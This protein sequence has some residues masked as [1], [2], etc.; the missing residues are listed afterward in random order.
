MRARKLLVLLVA[1][2]SL[3]ACSDGGGN[4][5]S[6][7]GGDGSLD[8][9]TNGGKL[10]VCSSNDVPYF[11]RDPKSGDLTGT[12]YDMVSE[13]A[14]RIGV[15]RIEMFEVPISGIIPALNSRRC[16][17]ISDNIAITVKRSQEVD[18]SAP[19]YLAGQ[20]L[21]VPKGN[22]ANVRTEN[23]FGGRRVGSYQGTVQLDYLKGLAAK[24]PSIEV[25]EYKNITEIVADL[26]AGRLDAGAFD[27][28][29]AADMIAQ[30]PSLRIEVV[31]YEMP[32]GDYAVGAAFRKDD[33][34]L[35]S[36]FN[37]ANREIMLDGTLMRIFQKWGL[38]PAER[39]MPF[40][41][42]CK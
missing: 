24:D 7:T 30:N 14:Q 20:A 41:G 32:I 27:D 11:Y 10:V 2:A 39:Y 36:A 31:D 33:N 8:R 35:Q 19:M 38:Q 37:D 18:F 22:P 21:V 3:A 4:E 5:D 12:D 13:I 28:M 25:K 15:G 26:E 16:D 1:S 17:M 42:C 40:P 6:N 34:D 23:D 29:V 9:V